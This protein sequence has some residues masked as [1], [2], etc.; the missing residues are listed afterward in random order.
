MTNRRSD[1]KSLED[2]GN[3]QR[4]RPASCLSTARPAYRQIIGGEVLLAASSACGGLACVLGD[5]SLLSLYLG[6]NGGSLQVQANS[7][8]IVYLT[9]LAA[10]WLGAHF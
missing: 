6:S 5:K 7:K 2:S 3:A 1:L 10:L 9:L 8:A 4:L